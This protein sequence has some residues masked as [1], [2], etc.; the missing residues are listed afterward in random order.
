MFGS[1]TRLSMVLIHNRPLNVD[2]HCLYIVFIL[3]YFRLYIA[4]LE[5]MNVFSNINYIHTS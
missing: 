5:K 4:G 3:Y 2:L 1:A